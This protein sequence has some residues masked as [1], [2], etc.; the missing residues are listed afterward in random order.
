M[1]NRRVVPAIVALISFASFPAEARFLQVDPVGYK[2]QAN[3]Y[4][5]VNNDPANGKDPTGLY[6]CA[7]GND[8]TK[9]EAYRQSL[10]VARD[11][12]ETNSSEYKTLSASLAVI[13]DPNTAGITIAEGGINKNAS[14]SATMD[15]STK[16]LTVY[17]PTLEL[18]AKMSGNDATKYGASTIGHESAP[19][20]FRPMSTRADRLSNEIAG[21]T[22]QETSSR[23]LGVQD[24]TTDTAYGKTKEDRVMF[25]ARGS[26]Y[27]ACKGSTQPSCQ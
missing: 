12:Y 20:H 5:Y 3:L 24:V 27:A 1:S 23:A 19:D 14:V 26:V 4:A 17:T 16:T 25:G 6:E 9:F 8:C 22:A 2:D 18:N 10:I 7:K 11:S 13:G 21:Y 15:P